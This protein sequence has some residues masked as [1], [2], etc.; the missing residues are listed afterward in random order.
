M[1]GRKNITE[2]LFYQVSLN[3]LVPE[4]N[5]YRRLN[6]VLD[7][8]F[9]YKTTA[10]YYGIEGQKSIDP[11]V[12]LKICLVGYLNDIISDRKL[13]S[14]CS[15]SLAIRLFLGYDL[16]EKLPW[17]STIS[18]TRQLYQDDV[19]EDVFNQI[20]KQCIASGLVSGHTQAVDSAFVKANASMDSLELKVPKESLDDYLKRVRHFSEMDKEA[21]HRKAKEDK[22]S[23]S[24]KNIHASDSK[25]NDINTR[26]KK[27]SKDQDQRPGAGNKS[28]KYTSNHTHY[29]P[30]DP[31]AKISVKPGK[32]RKLNY[33]AQ[34]AVDTDHQIITHI[35]ADLA[36]KK[37]NQYLQS[38]VGKAVE[39]LE[40]KGIKVENILADAGYSSGENYAW[41]EAQNLKSYIPPHGTY[42]GGPEGFEYVEEGNYWLCPNNKKVTFRKQRIEKDTLKDFYFTKR[43]DC[44]DCPL[45][46]TCIGKQHEKRISITAYRAEYERNNARLAQNKRHKSQRM[47]TVEPV[48]GTLINFLG[49]RKVNTRGQSGANKCMLMAATAFN[50]KKLLKYAQEPIKTMAKS[51]EIPKMI[52]QARGFLSFVLYELKF[53]ILS[54]SKFQ[55]ISSQLN[56]NLS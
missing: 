23:E 36:D 45:K 18:R 56:F 30:V 9:L 19:F 12:F 46:A 41:L 11:V 42:K 28:S 4:D 25:L 2:K 8:H 31:D 55:N 1:Q 54:H 13:I 44:K 38:L 35:Q 29:S 50:L 24:Q 17:H 48:F 49:M 47:A 53:W 39:N 37:D 21:P 10:K 22:A 15:D 51:V 34:M 26:Q 14:F 16:D 40:S 43:S 27:W 52:I 7:L 6:E 33:Y 20:L 3:D 5:F 32:A